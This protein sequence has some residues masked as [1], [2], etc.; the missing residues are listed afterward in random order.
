MRMDST[1]PSGGARSS[2]GNDEHSNVERELG[3][4]KAGDA[5]AQV[6]EV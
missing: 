3:C 4:R 2:L 5:A 6:P 1:G